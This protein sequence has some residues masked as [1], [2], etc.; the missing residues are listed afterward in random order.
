MKKI[1]TTI[2]LLLAASSTWAQSPS[3]SPTSVA[4]PGANPVADMLTGFA[5]YVE[6]GVMQTSSGVS[7][8]PLPCGRLLVT[9]IECSANLLEDAIKGPNLGLSVAVYSKT[10]KEGVPAAISTRVYLAPLSQTSSTTSTAFGGTAAGSVDFATPIFLDN[11]KTAAGTACRLG[12]TNGTMG[13]LGNID[14]VDFSYRCQL[15]L[16]VYP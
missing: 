1:I 2:F 5:R 6:V 3:P 7:S 4:I 9:H 13:I 15:H 8:D 10:K 12:Q 14:N 16:V 11:R